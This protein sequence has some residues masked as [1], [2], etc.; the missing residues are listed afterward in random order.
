MA[1][2]TRGIPLSKI[3]P[4]FLHSNATSHTWPFSAIA[5]LIDNAYDPDVAADELR[6]DKCVI[7]G[8]LCM[9]FQ[10]DGNG[11]TFEHLLKMLSFGYCEKDEFENNINHLPIGHYGNGFKSGSMRLGKDAVVLTASKKS[12]SVG[13][14]S[15]TYLEAIG[16]DCVF[17][18][19]IEYRLPH[20]ERFK[21]QESRNN[22]E[23]ILKQS[24]F[25][26]EQDL[27]NELRSLLK[28]KS[29]T[30][31]KI[32]LYNLRR[33]QGGKLE[34]DFESDN[35][36]IRNPESHE[37]DLTSVYH[38]TSQVETSEYMRSLRV[39]CGLL[40]LRPRMKIYIRGEKVK[41]Q[42]ISKSL[43]STEIDVYKPTWL[44]K[45]LRITFGF[46]TKSP[47]REDYGV[48]FYHRNR[49]IKA[50]EKLG[51]QKQPN[52]LGTGVV[53]VVQVDFLKPVHNKQDFE[54][55]EKYN[56]IMSAI[57]LKLNDYW[58][59]KKNGQ[60]GPVDALSPS[61]I[62]DWLWVQCERCL[63]W[64]RLPDSSRDTGLPDQW[65]CHM[66]PDPTHNRCD[67]V[68]EPEDEDEAVQRPTYAKTFKKKQEEKKRKRQADIAA[69]EAELKAREAALLEAQRQQ[70]MSEVT[71]SQQSRRELAALQ[72]AL[73]EAKKREEDHKRL[74]VKI[75]YQKRQSAAQQ[76]SL[77]A[78]AQT[79]QNGTTVA[80][81][82]LEVA[83]ALGVESPVSSTSG[84]RGKKRR[85]MSSTSVKKIMNITTEQGDM[86]TIERAD[87]DDDDDEP[88][89]E[90][91]IET[92]TAEE[93]HYEYM[94]PSS[95]A[96]AS[97]SVA[98]QSSPA[99]KPKTSAATSKSSTPSATSTAASTSSFSAAT[100]STPAAASTTTSS[101]VV[102]PS[103]DTL[104]HPEATSTPKPQ[105][106]RR[107]KKAVSE[108]SMIDLTLEEGDGSEN[109]VNTTVTAPEAADVKP[110]VN[111]LNRQ[112]QAD[113][114]KQQPL[115]NG[116]QEGDGDEEAQAD[117]ETESSD[118]DGKDLDPK[119]K[120]K[121]EEDSKLG[122]VRHKYKLL[123]Q[124]FQNLQHNVHKLLSFIVP[125]VNLGDEEDIEHIVTEMIRV[126]CNLAEQTK[127]SSSSSS[128]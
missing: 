63:K 50:Y 15:Q 118:N 96:Q 17:V 121:V 117:K 20:L 64:R 83:T 125:D 53:G 67:I 126:N 86:M 57:G 46:S 34:L 48:M 85:R 25:R 30:G 114:E 1:N 91:T 128:S 60:T 56:A 90:P 8:Q 13:F 28:N 40:F 73:Q 92:D 5:E 66:N 119:V 6:I 68:E 79:L 72:R 61:Q 110:D 62:A 3:S 2:L 76:H 78:A 10:D 113:A 44:T 101:V 71:S 37:V 22:L 19:M 29:A 24:P 33:H 77:V 88:A 58:N 55:D 84:K 108:V 87:T 80:S 16:A 103:T 100:P 115:L 59:E 123:T 122:Q 35:T 47:L 102:T 49:L 12:A 111:E 32:V 45:P 82:L 93:G 94:E 107:S 51:Y 70:E 120:V 99:S 124:R 42:L 74:I 39:Y 104:S 36:D 65:F 109:E 43:S 54:K 116:E 105:T 89:E 41:T 31:T 23:A 127:E 38:R 106:S 9:V 7:H 18:P 14:L 81:E 69:K 4:K 98:D 11:M 75:Q 27:K 52:D 97:D 21:S 112:L 95:P 26:T